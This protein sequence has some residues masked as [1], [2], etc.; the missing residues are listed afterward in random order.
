VGR[1]EAALA[2]AATLAGLLVLG[3]AEAAARAWSAQRPAQLS[4]ERLDELHVYSERYGWTPRPGFVGR[5]RGRLTSINARGYRGPAYDAAPRPGRRRVLVLGDSIAFGYGVADDETFA[6]RLDARRAEVEVV[7]LAVEGYGT[8]QQLLKLE[9][10]GLGHR[11]HVVLLNVCVE[12]DA[13]DNW[14]ASYLYDASFRQPFFTY[15]R[16]RLVLHDRHLA[17]G[18]WERAR[19]ALRTHS[20]L[21]GLLRPPPPLA[22]PDG[23]GA[24]WRQAKDEVL[25]DPRRALELT[26]RLIRAAERRTREAGAEFRVVLHPNKRALTGR[27]SLL[28][29]YLEAPLLDGI[30]RLDL[31][32]HYRMRGLAPADLFLDGSGHLNERGHREA[33]DA[34]DAWLHPAAD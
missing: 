12:N 8:A 13:L 30:P 28:P 11:P 9:H 18:P 31:A 24:R 7:N 19:L 33:A 6:R 5:F 23:A 34:L 32:A 26:F 1:R 14:R 21:L 15:E 25:R 17:L 29:A 22:P 20:R 4:G 16:G 27:A 2:V 3:A 10:E